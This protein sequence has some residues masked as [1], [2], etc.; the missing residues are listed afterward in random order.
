MLRGFSEN[1]GRLIEWTW[2]LVWHSSS[3]DFFKL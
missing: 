1:T 2:S 3:Y